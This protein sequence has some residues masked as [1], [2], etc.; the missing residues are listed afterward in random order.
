MAPS[1]V[2]NHYIT[3]HGYKRRPGNLLGAILSHVVFTAVEILLGGGMGSLVL[4]LVC[5]SAEL[6]I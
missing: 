6:V 1:K 4:S 3:A 2:Y 5:L